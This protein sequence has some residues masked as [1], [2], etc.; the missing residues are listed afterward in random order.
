M[1]ANGEELPARN[2]DHQL[3]GNFVNYTECHI[4]SD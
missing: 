2:K 4:T 1:L 3:K